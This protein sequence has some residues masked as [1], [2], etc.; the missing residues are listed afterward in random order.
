MEISRT[1]WRS[2]RPSEL[3]FSNAACIHP[4]RTD[5]AGGFGQTVALA[6]RRQ[7]SIRQLVDAP[8]GASQPAGGGA[9]GATEADRRRNTSP[10]HAIDDAE[11][12]HR[13]DGRGAE[14][15]I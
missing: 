3:M 1:R 8:A 12:V 11:E 6:P 7:R 9:S 4:A 14:L 5:A 10:C 2:S 13:R 15:S